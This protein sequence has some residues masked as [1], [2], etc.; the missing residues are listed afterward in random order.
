MDCDATV[1]N[2]WARKLAP[3]CGETP[4]T[5]EIWLRA[6]LDAIRLNRCQHVPEEQRICGHENPVVGANIENCFECRLTLARREGHT[7]AG[8]Y[9]TAAEVIELASRR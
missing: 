3:L 6:F 5:C 8:M 1:I 2:E 4:E 9:W 7:E